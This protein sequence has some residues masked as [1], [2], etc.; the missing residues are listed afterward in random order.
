MFKDQIIELE[1]RFRSSSLAKD[2]FWAV[3][4]SVVGKGLSLIAGILIARFL[5][6]EIYGEYGLIKNTLIYLAIVSTFGFGYTA[7]K[8]VAEY[9]ESN[10][11]NIG[12]LVKRIELFTVCFSLILT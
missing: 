10:N 5:G 7:T 3:L 11:P 9:K 12:W 6:K 2:S 4:G 8:Y 1:R